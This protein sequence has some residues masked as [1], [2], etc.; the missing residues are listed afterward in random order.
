MY[1]EHNR[2]WMW[3]DVPVKYTNPSLTDDNP[4]D[5]VV[6]AGLVSAGPIGRW[7]HDDINKENYFICQRVKREVM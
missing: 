2:T 4:P 1:K 6:W 3:S 7:E 5:G